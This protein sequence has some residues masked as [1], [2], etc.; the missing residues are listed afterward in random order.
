MIRMEE[1]HSLLVKLLDSI[2]SKR[3][4]LSFDRKIKDL[5]PRL[6]S[7]RRG[8]EPKDMICN[9]CGI[10]HEARDFIRA[11]LLHLIDGLETNDEYIKFLQDNKFLKEGFNPYKENRKEPISAR[12]DTTLLKTRVRSERMRE[13]YIFSK[14]KIPK[15]LFFK[16]KR[17]K[18]IK[19]WVDIPQGLLEGIY[20]FSRRGYESVIKQFPL[21][22]YKL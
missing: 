17:Y 22:I 7:R 20:E 16:G 14:G 3:D 1:I 5:R 4:S 10:N 13:P 2:F 11:I 8:G 12:K 9:H 19:R 18:D 21:H 6:E 15:I